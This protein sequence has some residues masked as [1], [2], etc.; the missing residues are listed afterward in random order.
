M[1]NLNLVFDVTVAKYIEEM[2]CRI[3]C[4]LYMYILYRGSQNNLNGI[5]FL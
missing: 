4:I 3:L 1:T 2:V 5:I